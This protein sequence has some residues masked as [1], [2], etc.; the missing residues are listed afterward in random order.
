MP[1]GLKQS[2]HRS[3]HFWLKTA[4]EPLQAKH[5]GHHFHPLALLLVKNQFTGTRKRE[6]IDLIAMKNLQFSA[7]LQ[8]IC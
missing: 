5:D 4:N 6:A 1:F 8:E 7:S 3:G 2:N